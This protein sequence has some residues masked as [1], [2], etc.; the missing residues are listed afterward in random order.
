MYEVHRE[1]RVEVACFFLDGRASK[2]W[3]W[4]KFKF[5][6]EGKRL[7]W[8]AFEHEFLEQWGPSPMI[9][10]HGQLAN[11]KQEGKVQDYI[12]ELWC[13]MVG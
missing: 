7:G 9:N 4:L 8:T 5:E 10:P 2:W 12:E 3:R 1:E 6:Q 13:W 11:L